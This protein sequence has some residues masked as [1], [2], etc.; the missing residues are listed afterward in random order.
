MGPELSMKMF[1]PLEELGVENAYG[2]AKNV[3]VNSE[4]IKQ[5]ITED[6]VYEAELSLLRQGLSIAI[7]SVPG[8]SRVRRAWC[9]LLCG[10]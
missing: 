2:I 3:T 6:E 8:G 1:E 7:S 4:G 5:V 9:I 10:L